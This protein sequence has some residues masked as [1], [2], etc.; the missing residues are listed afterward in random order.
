MGAVYSWVFLS[1]T[2]HRAMNLNSV[3]AFLNSLLINTMKSM[4]L[5]LN[6]TFLAL[7]LFVV[8]RP[9]F[10]FLKLLTVTTRL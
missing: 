5:V 6:L 2:L 10:Y 9:I 4:N 1:G 8:F 3:G 7:F